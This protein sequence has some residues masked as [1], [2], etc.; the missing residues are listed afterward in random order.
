[1]LAYHEYNGVT[2]SSGG[3]YMGSYKGDTVQR[4]VYLCGVLLLT[5]MHYALCIRI[6]VLHTWG[7]TREIQYG[8]T[9]SVDGNSISVQRVISLHCY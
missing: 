4:V 5:T 6:A 2:S 1:V 8:I 9:C 3:I 7:H